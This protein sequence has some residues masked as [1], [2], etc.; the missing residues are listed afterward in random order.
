MGFVDE[1]PGSTQQFL[2]LK[3]KNCLTTDM[4]FLN[5]PHHKWDKVEKSVI[6]PINYGRLE[7]KEV[8]MIP[9][10]NNSNN[11]CNVVSDLTVKK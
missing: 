2:N 8:E 9:E 4:T 5:K 3:T 6:I 11:S 10:S 7:E 1:H